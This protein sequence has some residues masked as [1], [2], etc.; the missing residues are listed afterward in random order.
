MIS[1]IKEPLCDVW[2]EWRQ[3]LREYRNLLWICLAF[4]FFVYGLRIFRDHIFIDSEL[5]I[6]RPEF[7]QGVWLG[8]GR[9]G[10][11][12]TSR[13]FGM[14]R[15]VPYLQGGGYSLYHVLGGDHLLEIGRA[16]V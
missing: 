8:S 15:L 3:F 9:F 12:L 5:M 13:L 10:L 2:R 6:L 4:V 14:G 11:V 1:G 16:H 7:M